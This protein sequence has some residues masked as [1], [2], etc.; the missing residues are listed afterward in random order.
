MYI[1]LWKKGQYGYFVRYHNLFLMVKV[2]TEIGGCPS[3]QLASEN[4]H[5]SVALHYRASCRGGSELLR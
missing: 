4:I 1:S 3:K 5:D 2:H